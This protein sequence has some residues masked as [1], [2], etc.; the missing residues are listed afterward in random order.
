MPKFKPDPD[1]VVST[2]AAKSYFENS[3]PFKR[4]SGEQTMA[5]LEYLF[6]RDINN[7]LAY[8]QGGDEDSLPLVK[9][10][11]RNYEGVEH[12]ELL[13]MQMLNMVTKLRAVSE[14]RAEHGPSKAAMQRIMTDLYNLFDPQNPAADVQRDRLQQA[15]QHMGLPTL[16]RRKFADRAGGGSDRQPVCP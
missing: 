12:I 11:F 8:I 9:P 16:G 2:D 1:T 7:R 10:E 4:D 3:I 15:A 14:G 13:R 5:S 6:D